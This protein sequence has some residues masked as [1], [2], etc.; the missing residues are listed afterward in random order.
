MSS[1]CVEGGFPPS[2]DPTPT[3]E[4]DH[5][6]LSGAKRTCPNLIEGESE[7]LLI[8]NCCSQ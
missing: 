4:A 7:T 1:L 2:Q 3:L 5:V 8:D 6:A